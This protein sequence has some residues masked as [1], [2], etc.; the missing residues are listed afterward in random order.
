MAVI[1]GGFVGLWSAIELKL[2][3]PALDVALLEAD[4]CGSGA[5]GRN[6]GFALTWWSK[7]AL[8][9]NYLGDEESLRLARA[10]VEGIDDLD[11]LL[12][13]H[14]TGCDFLKGG[15]IWAAAAES[16]LGAWES[17]L[18]ECDRLG[19]T[20]F[21]VLDAAEVVRRTGSSVHRAGIYDPS[22]ARVH[23]GKMA[24]GLRKVALDLGV[25]LFEHT[26]VTELDRG[27][28]ASLRTREGTMTADKVVIA[29]NVWAAGMPEFRRL[30]VAISSDMVITEPAPDRLDEIGWTRGEC[31]SDS[32]MMIHYYQRT[33]DGRVAFGKGGW[34]I[35]LGGRITPSFDRSP[36]RAREVERNFRRIY[37][38]LSDLS[39][40]AD[41]S[42]AID[43][44][45]TGIP[46]IGHTGGRKHIVHAVGW[47]ANAVGPA[48]VGARF[49]AS[50]VQE[51]DDEWSR[52]PLVDLPGQRF[53]P[54]PVR[55]LG[56]HVVRTGVARKERAEL[57]GRAPGR[58]SRVL[59]DQVPSGLIP[60]E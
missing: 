56:A 58:I 35:A 4:V 22:T 30:I 14:H 37:P 43:R 27:R 33:A 29:T 36:S 31:I 13:D 50:L 25:R 48:R 7:I 16:Q 49:V 26:P 54:E 53:P 8:F 39:I 47:S 9:P 19:V 45:V 52:S 20:P 41:W 28:P 55:Y 18:K 24:R 46:L 32:Q 12:K 59:A 34:G 17:T 10:S 38:M 3:E 2:R 44:S 15:W 40:V 60:K 1:G 6:G 42:G 51:R 23:P 11:Q 5:S 21:K 57:K